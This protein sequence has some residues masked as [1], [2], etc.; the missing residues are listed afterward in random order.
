MQTDMTGG[1]GTKLQ[2]VTVHK[3][4]PFLH[5][6]VAT[7]EIRAIKPPINLVHYIFA[8]WSD[9]HIVGYDKEAIRRQTDMSFDGKCVPL[10]KMSYYSSIIRIKRKNL[11]LIIVYYFHGIPQPFSGSSCAIA[12]QNCS[13]KFREIGHL[14]LTCSCLL[15]YFSN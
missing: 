7:H 12:V 5:T 15:W 9:I 11:S 1:H 4:L 3:P 6:A 13:Q 2:G 14:L 10:A 8:R